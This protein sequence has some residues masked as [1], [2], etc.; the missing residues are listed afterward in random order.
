M[1]QQETKKQQGTTTTR[2][3]RRTTTERSCMLDV[4]QILFVVAK[5]GCCEIGLMCFCCPSYG[6]KENTTLGQVLATRDFLA[7]K[8]SPLKEKGITSQ[9]NQGT[10]KQQ[11]TT[12]RRT[13]RNHLFERHGTASR[14][15]CSGHYRHTVFRCRCQG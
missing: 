5:D 10:N 2:R 7:M 6:T 12:R 14:I 9:R 8:I 3:R 4:L 13:N 11:A 1:E 15:F